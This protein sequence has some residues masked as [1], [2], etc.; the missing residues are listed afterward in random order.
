RRCRPRTGGRSTRGTPPAAAAPGRTRGS[1]VR[2]ALVCAGVRPEE[3]M[4]VEA[5][6][7]R[8]VDL[9]VA[10]DREIHGD[11]AAWPSGLP[12]VDIVVLRAKSHRRNVVL[13]RWLESRGVRP[14]NAAA[15]LET[16]GD[17]VST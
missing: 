6:R 12:E 14:V 8:D 7:A 13:A 11:L 1:G 4:L 15:V 9:V 2:V 17:K 3:K 10:D 5:F 16:C